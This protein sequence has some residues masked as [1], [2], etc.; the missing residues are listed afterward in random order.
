MAGQSTTTR[1]NLYICTSEF[2]LKASPI[3]N[4]FE[5]E[6]SKKCLSQWFYEAVMFSAEPI[7]L[8]C[9]VISAHS[10]QYHTLILDQCQRLHKRGPKL[11]LFK[12]SLDWKAHLF[13]IVSPPCPH[14][15]PLLFT[16]KQRNG[17]FLVNPEKTRDWE[18]DFGVWVVINY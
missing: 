2:K 3:L 9:A 6:L 11:S 1:Y 8:L 10:Y 18:S 15:N 7:S 12:C 17:L 5:E 13:P 16:A 4:I 14:S